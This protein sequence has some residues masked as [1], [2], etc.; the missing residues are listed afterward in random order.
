M[1]VRYVFFNTSNL[2]TATLGE[3]QETK[4]EFLVLSTALVSEYQT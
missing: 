3:S 2:I 4:L 1:L